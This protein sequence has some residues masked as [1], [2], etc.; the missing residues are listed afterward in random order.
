MTADTASV[1][2]GVRVLHC[3]PDGPVLANDRDAADVVGAAI[4]H[5]ATLIGIPV[6]R[7]TDGFFTLRTRI[8]GEIVGK[9]VNYRLRVAIIGDIADHLAA[10]SALRDWVTES[11]RGRQLWFVTD[12]AE[13]DR[14]LAA[15]AGRQ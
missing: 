8:A 1:H 9:L 2:H 13:L 7:L 5:R 15:E 12:L 14:R 10:S 11:N 4:S 3:A 6:A